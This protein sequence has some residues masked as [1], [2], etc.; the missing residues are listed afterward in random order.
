MIFSY[1]SDKGCTE[2]AK[3]QQTA[4]IDLIVYL[5]LKIAN[6]QA[7]PRAVNSKVNK[8]SF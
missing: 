4:F 5:S 1:F 6:T 3:I 7:K 8:V 2:I